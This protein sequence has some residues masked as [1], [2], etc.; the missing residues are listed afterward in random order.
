MCSQSESGA[1]YSQIKKTLKFYTEKWSHVEMLGRRA[2]LSGSLYFLYNGGLSIYAIL[3]WV[4]LSSSVYIAAQERGAFMGFEF[5]I[6]GIVSVGL[7]AYL[8]Y[9]LFNAEKL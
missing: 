1:V 4:C 3:T 8:V 5:V 9:A 6:G 2:F 7:F